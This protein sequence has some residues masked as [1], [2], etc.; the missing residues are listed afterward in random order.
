MLP[1]TRLITTT[2]ILIAIVVIAGCDI[3]AFYGP[4]GWGET[5]DPELLAVIS[6]SRGDRISA[7]DRLLII[8]D[9]TEQP[10]ALTIELARSGAIVDTLARNYRNSGDFTWTVPSDFAPA[11]EVYD[12]YQI[13]V[14]GFHPDQSIGELELI[15]YSERFT[16]LPASG[17]GLSDIT[18]SSRNVI[19]TLTDN[20][21]EV[22]GDTI[23]LRLNGALVVA[24]HVLVG[25]LGT[26]FALALEPGENTL[27]IYAVNEGSITPNTALME[28][29]DV[30][31]GPVAQEWR[32]LAG[33]TGTLTVT[34]P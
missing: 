28:V 13:V 22:D 5:T 4:H 34:A 16:I 25:G 7:G 26:S 12:E 29:T 31:E 17:G 6:P 14:R 21:T 11:S 27:S 18:V 1:R 32:L 23:D 20:G 9:G 15:A 8:W 3:A 19:I 33:E 2:T 30:I 10:D 24:N